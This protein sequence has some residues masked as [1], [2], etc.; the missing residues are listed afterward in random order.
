MPIIPVSNIARHG[1]VSDEPD[2]MQPPEAWTNALNMRFIDSKATKFD[3][4]FAIMEPP[5]VAPA[6]V[7][8]I[9]AAGGTYWLYASAIGAGSKVYVYNSGTHTDISRVSNYTA[10]GAEDWNS[11][12]FQG[13]PILNN[14]NDVPQYWSAINPATD[15]ADLP[16]WPG[17]LRAEIISSYKNFMVALN[18]TD[19]STRLPHRVRTS[20]SAEPGTVPTSWDETDP[21]VDVFEQDLSDVNSG[22]ILWGAPLRDFFAI[23]KG[24]STWTLRFIGGQ[25]VM[26]LDPSLQTSGILAKR[27]A[28][29]ITLPIGNVQ[30]HFVHTGQDLGIYDGQN[31]KSVIDKKIRK[32]LNGIIDPTTY[33][34]SFVVDNPAQDEAWFCYPENGMSRPNMALVWNYRRDTVTFRAL[35]GDHAAT[36][37][38]EA[39]N[40]TTWASLDTS[41]TWAN[42]GPQ[43]WQDSSRRKMVIADQAHTHLLQA[44]LGTD[45]NGTLFDSYVERTA[46]AIIGQDREG[47]PLLDY[48]QR[49]L[50]RRLW[51]KARGNP[52]YV[53]YGGADK[54]GGDVVYNDPVVYDPSSE[55]N[56][57]DPDPAPLNVRLPALKFVSKDGLPFSIEGYDIDIEPLGQY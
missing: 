21:A 35:R 36:G 44:D 50:M 39:S 53:Y 6:H 49:R 38:V 11:T 55:I 8:N 4:D 20:D 41:I 34:K 29:P 15:L 48:Q 13:I 26:S 30:V 56:F 31:F 43:A 27:C 22:E 12:I 52:F 7:M 42:I 25:N 24:E 1:I 51:P 28:C 5:T 54:V 18:L 47:N 3:G 17:T 45:F 37:V 14:G 10:D 19:G 46:L 32:Q 57:V 9:Q 33:V 16:N 40:T 2:H 23:Y